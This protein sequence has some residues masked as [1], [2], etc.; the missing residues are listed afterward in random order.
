MFS[1]GF[2]SEIAFP[3]VPPRLSDVFN[4]TGVYLCTYV[5][6]LESGNPIIMC[7]FPL[8]KVQG[9]R[10]VLSI[11]AVETTLNTALL[12]VRYTS[13]EGFFYNM[14]VTIYI[15]ISGLFRGWAK[16]NRSPLHYIYF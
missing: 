13:F 14:Y 15:I 9:H 8:K 5:H 12:C 4:Y 10:T 16:E 6:I 11:N 7:E 3:F 1:A 2:V